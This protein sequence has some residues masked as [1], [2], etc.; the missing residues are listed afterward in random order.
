MLKEELATAKALHASSTASAA[1]AATTLEGR[2][3]ELQTRLS[4]ASEHHKL[5]QGQ[6]ETELSE[7]RSQLEDLRSRLEDAVSERDAL[8]DD[9]EGW[10]SR[11]ADL[12]AALERER[13]AL[14]TEKKDGALA[15]EKVRKLGDKLAALSGA[16]DAAEE[17]D[18]ALTTAQAKLINEMRDQI[19]SLAAALDQE[20]RQHASVAQQLQVLQ[21]EQSWQIPSHHND[22]V[23]AST[24]SSFLH[25]SLGSSFGGPAD[26]SS[27][28]SLSSFDSSMGKPE[29]SASLNGPGGLQ[30]LAEE[31]EED[32]E[33]DLEAGPADEGVWS[34]EDDVPELDFHGTQTHAEHL[35]QARQAGSTSSCASFGDDINET[36]TPPP[37]QEQ[38]Q[39]ASNHHRSDSFIKQWTFPRGKVTP[40]SM[41]EPDDHSFFSC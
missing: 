23:D 9:V 21:N 33:R 29:F 26:E 13:Q 6:M 4:E 7:M 39:Q 22:S 5:A 2:L 11:C 35:N 19:F 30:T 28:T 18:D 20:K 1:D 24:A 32:A 34:D 10:R 15:R 25:S 41:L 40:I 27:F 37:P 3:S 16:Q 17:K 38:P 8:V 36:R 31:D 14:D 12:T